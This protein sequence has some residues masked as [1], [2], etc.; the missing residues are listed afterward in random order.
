MAIAHA[1]GRAWFGC[2]RISRRRRSCRRVIFVTAA[3]RRARLA[4]ALAQRP[5]WRSAAA[6]LV[7]VRTGL[8]MECA[9]SSRLQRPQEL[10]ARDQPDFDS[11]SGAASCCVRTRSSGGAFAAAPCAL[12]EVCPLECQR[13]D[14]AAARCCACLGCRPLSGLFAELVRRQ[15]PR[16]VNAG[17]HGRGFGQRRHARRARLRRAATA[18]VPAIVEELLFSWRF[19][20]RVSGAKQPWR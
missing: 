3:S 9:S 16:D 19:D 2:S 11:R 7:V 5:A 12:H 4:M 13:R 15:L 8:P 6:A 20:A 1:R 14:L 17:V 18:L 10:A